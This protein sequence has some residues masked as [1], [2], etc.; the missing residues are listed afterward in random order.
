MVSEWNK[1]NQAA[2]LFYQYTPIDNWYMYH[3]LLIV[4]VL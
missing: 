1:Y 3:D 4:C 2:E